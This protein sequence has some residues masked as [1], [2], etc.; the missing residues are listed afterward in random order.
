MTTM[1]EQ[2]QS[3]DIGLTYEQAAHGIQSVKAHELAAAPDTVQAADA[4]KKYETKHMRVGIDLS[5]S[6]Q[7]GL[8]SLLIDKG[9]FTLEEYDEYMR[10]AANQELRSEEIHYGI[11]FR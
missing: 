6:D 8:A 3:W 9:V 10:L 11:T 4:K 1:K 7:M 2:M 5:K